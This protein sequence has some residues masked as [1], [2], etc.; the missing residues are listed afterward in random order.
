[1]RLLGES[2]TPDC[3]GALFW[4]GQSTLI[5]ADLHLEKGSA[6]AERRVFLPPYDTAATL[7]RL[8]AAMARHRPARVIALGDSFHD[9][10][11]GGRLGEEDRA[12]L[13]ALTGQTAD[14]IWLT[15]NHDPAPPQGL[16][17]RILPDF[18]LGP[19]R[20]VHEP[21]PGPAPG[22]IA[23]HLHPAAG[24]LG[25]GR[26]VRRRCF[27]TDGV[28]LIMPAF[29]AYAG[30]LCVLDPAISSLLQAPFAAWLLGRDRVYPV[31][32]G[33]LVPDVSPSGI[34][35]PMPSLR[36]RSS[37]RPARHK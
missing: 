32:S 19:F 7:A 3:S 12:A 10:R 4:P 26:K 27:A 20:L 33:R 21:S 2:F 6:F 23:G 24:V 29:G 31:S 37:A 30:G 36:A 14:W 18:E 11:A 17:G 35:A 15:G 1:M 22:E 34:S 5:V 28:R 16:G 9:R 8:A 25:Q 13:L